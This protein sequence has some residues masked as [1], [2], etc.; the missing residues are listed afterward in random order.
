MA[1][2]RP[3]RRER[4]SLR[5]WAGNRLRSLR[6]LR[7]TSS[8]NS[9]NDDGRD[10]GSSA[11]AR[12]N[13]CST[14]A[15]RRTPCSRG[16]GR[17]LVL[18]ARA[19][20]ALASFSPIT[21]RSESASSNTRAN[22]YTSV[23]GPVGPSVVSSC[24]GAA[25][26][27]KRS[28]M[29]GAFVARGERVDTASPTARPT[30]KS[31]SLSVDSP[32]LDVARNMLLGVSARCSASCE[33]AYV[34][35]DATGSRARA[36]PRACARARPR[37]GDDGGSEPTTRPRTTRGRCELDLRP[38]AR[39]DHRSRRERL[40]DGEVA[41]RQPVVELAALDEARDDGLGES[42]IERGRQVEA[43][44]ARRYPH[45]DVLGAIDDAERSL[46]HDRVDAKLAI[47]HVADE[48][49]R[50]HPC[51]SYRSSTIPSA[52]T[53]IASSAPF[54]SCLRSRIS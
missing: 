15:G 13:A 12:T 19:I 46:A 52:A 22:A 36:P 38:R 9:A 7:E 44:H 5:R 40:G 20:S 4:R 31:S 54:G 1:T 11:S 47:E 3:G 25:Y 32:E 2:G 28:L 26:E 23:H 29:R 16:V 24:S 49:E 30:P 50:I 18:R 6:S 17:V 27:G 53:F 34:S 21:G 43:F 39:R 33:C 42:G 51:P 10:S 41:P 8:Q 37:R 14:C 45:R 48:I 35:A